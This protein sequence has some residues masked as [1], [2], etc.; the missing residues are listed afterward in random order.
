MAIACPEKKSPTKGTMCAWRCNYLPLGPIRSN[1]GWLWF[2]MCL[3]TLF[4]LGVT[5][6]AATGNRVKLKQLPVTSSHVTEDLEVEVEGV[7]DQLL[8]ACE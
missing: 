3:L 1:N 2:Q 6:A 8:A 4:W 5:A 7:D